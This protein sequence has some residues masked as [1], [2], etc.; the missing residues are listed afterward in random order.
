MET[1][2]IIGFTKHKWSFSKSKTAI[3][4]HKK[5]RKECHETTLANACHP[6]L[7]SWSRR[8]HVF[9]FRRQLYAR[10]VASD[11]PKAR[12][13]LFF[14]K[15]SNRGNRSCSLTPNIPLKNPLVVLCK[16]SYIN[17]EEFRL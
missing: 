9:G 13:G 7:P 10:R 16:I 17:A 8:H 14:S 5:M 12:P 6:L 2:G 15:H 3:S 11:T 4:K 1:T